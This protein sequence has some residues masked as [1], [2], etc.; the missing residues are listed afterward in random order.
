[1]DIAAFTGAGGAGQPVIVSAGL[2]DKSA[3]LRLTRP[4]ATARTSSSQP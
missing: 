3:H 4:A 1:M 2:A